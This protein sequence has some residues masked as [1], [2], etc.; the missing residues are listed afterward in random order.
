[1]TQQ[2]LYTLFSKGYNEIKQW[3]EWDIQEVTPSLFKHLMNLSSLPEKSSVPF[4]AAYALEKTYLQDPARFEPFIPRL[5]RDFCT[6][7]NPSAKRHYGKLT[8]LALRSEKREPT[9]KQAR[10]VAETAIERL[11][12]DSLK[13]AVRVWSLDILE[14]LKNRVPW[15]D[16]E[17]PGII[18]SLR[19]HPC[20]AML[21]RLKKTGWVKSSE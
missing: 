6:I 9:A 11:V 13:I 8:A 7:T 14:C 10:L 20:P 12:D 18:D 16:E 19:C 1:M 5:Y 21:S 17:L 15:I 4:R 3:E 2:E